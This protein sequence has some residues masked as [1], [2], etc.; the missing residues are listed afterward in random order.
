MLASEV[1]DG[2]DPD[3]A[4]QVAVELDQGVAVS[5]GRGRL[6]GAEEA[7]LYLSEET[8]DRRGDGETMERMAVGAGGARPSSSRRLP[9][10]RGRAPHAERRATSPGAPAGPGHELRV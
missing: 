6:P 10:R 5:H 9:R 8:R 3:V 2:A 7:R 4:V 1:E